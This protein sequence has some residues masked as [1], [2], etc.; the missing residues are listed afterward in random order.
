MIA[1]RH[2]FLVA[3]AGIA[4]TCP[5]GVGRARA[6]E[7]TVGEP[8]VKAVRDFLENAKGLGDDKELQGAVLRAVNDDGKTPNARWEGL[9]GDDVFVVVSKPMPRST[10]GA[11]TGPAAV[12]MVSVV[13]F[14]E[15]LKTSKAVSKFADCGLDDSD[16]LK[17]AIGRSGLTGVLKGVRHEEA[18]SGD[19]VVGYALVDA[20]QV[21]TAASAAENVTAVR[22][23]YLQCMHYRATE[24]INK[25][26]F[27]EAVKL[28]EKL[29]SDKLASGDILLSHAKA[30]HTADR[31][32]EAVDCLRG[33]LQVYVRGCSAGFIERL[34]DLALEWGADDVARDAFGA[35]SVKML[36]SE[37][38]NAE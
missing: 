31:K 35:G 27:D 32:A 37:S 13:A 1:F 30:L 10:G 4:L 25:G 23:A 20:A 3:V 6:G 18:V 14:N 9:H 28:C 5:S 21:R 11:R 36:E 24:L 22:R 29:R 17:K 34:G 12:K 19:F 2:G 7:E 38:V 8:C 15:L 33:D 16:M 26:A